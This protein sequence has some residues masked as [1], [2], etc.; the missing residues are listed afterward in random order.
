MLDMYMSGIKFRDF[1]QIEK[2]A[3]LSEN[4]RYLSESE[5][6]KY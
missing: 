5:C 1:S 3:K 4:L 2:I 6:H